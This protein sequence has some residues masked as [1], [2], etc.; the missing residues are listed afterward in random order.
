MSI[1]DKKSYIEGK[2]GKGKAQWL[3][4]NEKAVYDFDTIPSGSLYLDKKL[5]QAFPKLTIAEIIGEE[6]SGKTTLCLSIIAQAQKKYPKMYCAFIDVEHALDAKY[7]QDI[8]VDLKRLIISQ[9]DSAEEALMI[10]EDFV[11][12]NDCAVVVIDSVA[13]LVPAEELE[14]ELDEGSVSKLPQIMGRATRKLK[15]LVRPTETLVLF[16]NQYRITQFQ[17]FVKKDTPGGRALR[18]FAGIRIELKRSSK[19]IQDGGENIGQVCTAFIKKNKFN[20]PFREAEFFILFGKG[21]SKEDE[22]ID[23]GI[24]IGEI[25]KGG[26]YYTLNG[27]KV[28]GRRKFLN[29]L[30]ENPEITEKLEKKVRKYLFD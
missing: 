28:Q 12:D 9:P 17:P 24:E 14:K 22:L 4:G 13:G 1:A 16:T 18:F 27:H 3:D 15:N 7:A 8:G 11:R 5:G 26:A 30:M 20:A 25:Q 10:A 6:Q 29:Y 23:L 21:I 2:Y 19:L